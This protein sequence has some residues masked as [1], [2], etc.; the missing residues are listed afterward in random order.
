MEDWNSLI[1][2]NGKDNKG[3]KIFWLSTIHR[4]L[5]GFHDIGCIQKMLK[6]YW[7]STHDY[8]KYYLYFNV[9]L[10]NE[11]YSILIDDGLPTSL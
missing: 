8:S 9:I 7:Q 3:M 10:L 2:V 11:L 5:F 1:I 6:K 4:K